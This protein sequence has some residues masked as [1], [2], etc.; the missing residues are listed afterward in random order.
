M[1]SFVNYIVKE[2]FIL[3]DKLDDCMAMIFFEYMLP[4]AVTTIYRHGAIMR[5]MS[6]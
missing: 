6:P 1:K 2:K 5:K 3:F 4:N